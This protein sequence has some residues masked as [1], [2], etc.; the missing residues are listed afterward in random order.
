MDMYAG[1]C[2]L[3]AQQSF[4]L[5]LWTPHPGFVNAVIKQVLLR[6][7]RI[8]EICSARQAELLCHTIDKRVQSVL[9]NEIAHSFSACTRLLSSDA[10]T[11]C[12]QHQL[13]LECRLFTR[14]LAVLLRFPWSADETHLTFPSKFPSSEY[15]SWQI[16]AGHK[17][18]G[19]WYLWEDTS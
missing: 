9:D 8:E 2:I 19:F 6:R 4:R 7:R 1:R 12:K 10:V 14:T 17:Q 15:E 11:L 18:L 3:F 5:G 16:N 13:L